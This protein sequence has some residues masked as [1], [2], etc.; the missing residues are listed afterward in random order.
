MD[1]LSA[2]F[3]QYDDNLKRLLYENESLTIGA[4]DSNFCIKSRIANEN[5]WQNF[6]HYLMISSLSKMSCHND[7]VH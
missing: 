3:A 7:F 6:V 4:N 1:Q 2:F 5:C